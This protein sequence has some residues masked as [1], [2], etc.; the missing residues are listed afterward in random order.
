M[1]KK[2]SLDFIKSPLPCSKDWNEMAGDERVR[3]CGGCEKNVYNLSAMT[4]REASKFVARNSGKVCVRYIRLADGRVYTPDARLYKITRRVSTVAAGVVGATLTLA[5]LAGA[6]TPTSPKPESSQKVASKNKDVTQAS[7]I[8][9]IVTDANGAR[10][11]NAVVNLSNPQ[12]N[13]KFTKTTNDEGVA[14]FTGIPPA[15][16]EVKFSA[17]NFKD[18]KRSIRIKE[19]VEPDVE[20]YL[21]VGADVQVVGVVVDAWSEIPFFQAIERDDNEAVRKLVKS[22]IDLKTR[23]ERGNTALHVAVAGGN[24]EIVR[25]LLENGAKVNAKNKEKLTPIWMFEDGED[26]TLVKIFRLL[27][28][29]GADVNVLNEDKA[30]LLMMACFDDN[31]EAVKILLEA[32]ANPNLKDED[33]ETALQKTDSEEI[34]QLLKQYGAR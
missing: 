24:L 8:S 3:F 12:T 9:F 16:Y 33:G 30:S 34:K 26:E 27:I 1:A 29:K 32:G 7:Q 2:S 17:T 22:G 20:V 10:I 18:L 23:D 31:L 13:E 5:A 6:Q 21:E 28:A 15:T 14:L 25:L 11:P 19:T 4:R